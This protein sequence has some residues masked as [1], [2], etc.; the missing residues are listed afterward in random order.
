M[1]GAAGGGRTASA[2]PRYASD[3]PFTYAFG[4][5][6]VHEALA[7]RP[8]D[9][10]L[11]LWHSELPSGELATLQAAA[12]AAGVSALQDDATVLRLRRHA[13]VRCLAV[14]R[15]REERLA[16]GTDHVALVSPSHPGNVGTLIRSLVAFGYHDLALV[17]SP[18]DPW[19][20]YVVRA[21]VGLRFALRCQEFP[22]LADYATH[23]PGRSLYL[24]DAAGETELDEV[25]FVPPYT[26]LF[27]PEWR[28][29]GRT[30]PR[31]EGSPTDTAV[32]VR[33]PQDHRV[34]SLN[35]AVSVSVAAYVARR[36]GDRP[37]P[38]QGEPPRGRSA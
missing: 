6:A 12:E 23:H 22:T 32:T 13:A 8:A 35:L 14:V 29:S 28:P 4:R 15:K 36:L 3:L 27:G 26:L 11:V 10:E 33:I 5:F 9:V 18:I 38:G 1:S 17:A 20:A 24:F 16:A 31:P 25:E 2:L 30:A 19:G 21:S 7:W 34:E 37:T